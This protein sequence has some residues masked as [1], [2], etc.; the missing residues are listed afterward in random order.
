MFCPHSWRE[1]WVNGDAFFIFKFLF[2]QLFLSF[3]P[4]VTCAMVSISSREQT[5]KQQ[6]TIV[7]N[8]RIQA[9]FL[10]DIH[11]LPENVISCLFCQKNGSWFIGRNTVFPSYTYFCGGHRTSRCCVIQARLKPT[12]LMSRRQLGS[13]GSFLRQEGQVIL[14]L[15]NNCLYLLL[16]QGQNWLSHPQT[17][18]K[19][20]L[21]FRPRI[22]WKDHE[23]PMGWVVGGDTS[24]VAEHHS[25]QKCV[26]VSVCVNV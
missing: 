3:A 17:W 14:K 1:K 21:H 24:L 2:C 20:S 19:I 12:A 25:C 5:K 4:A 8:T 7:G 23:V 11:F 6:K 13:S 9:V 26:G 10:H 22:K 18:H 16:Q 15:C